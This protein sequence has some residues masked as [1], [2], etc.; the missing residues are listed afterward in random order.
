MTNREWLLELIKKR[1]AEMSDAELAENLC[2][3]FNG[4]CH[5]EEIVLCPAFTSY[6][7]CAFNGNDFSWMQ[8]QCGEGV[9]E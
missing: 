4:K 5:D 1:F 3:A 2:E 7:E 8:S 9:R 6:G